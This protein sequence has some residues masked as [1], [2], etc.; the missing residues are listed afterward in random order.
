MRASQVRMES[1]VLVRVFERRATD[2]IL[3]IVEHDNMFFGI[4]PDDMAMLS[5]DTQE[6]WRKCYQS[7]ELGLDLIWRSL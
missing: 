3:A 6:L 2:S 4:H 7:I 1:S 5:P